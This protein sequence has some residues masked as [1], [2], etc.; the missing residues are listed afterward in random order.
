MDLESSRWFCN[1]NVISKSK[2]N[3]KTFCLVVFTVI[4]S[5]LSVLSSLALLVIWRCTNH[6]PLSMQT[7][8]F[9]KERL[10]SY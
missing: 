10:G 8:P 3:N 6:L 9:A 1:P 4:Y 5:V 2:G 7:I